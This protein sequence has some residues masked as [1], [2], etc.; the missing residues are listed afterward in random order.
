MLLSTLECANGECRNALYGETDMWHVIELARETG[1][2]VDDDENAY[3]PEHAP[4]DGVL[5]SWVVGCYT[6]DFE[7]V[8]DSEEEAKNEWSMHECEPD[9]WIWDPKK[10]REME[11]RRTAKR[12]V[13]TAKVTAALS[14]AE[15]EQDR[16]EAYANQWLRIR[17]FFLPWKKITLKGTET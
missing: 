3:C 5:E 4:A 10:T 7:E 9:T 13:Q 1:W 2:L 12:S 15:A 6:C 17:N 8:Y 11:A 16:I 14:E